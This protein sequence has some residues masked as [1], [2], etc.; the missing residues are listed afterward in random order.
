MKQKDFATIQGFETD[1]FTHKLIS[2][3]TL[4]RAQDADGIKMAFQVM[5][6]IS[7]MD[8]TVL[9]LKIQPAQADA[10]TAQ[11]LEATMVDPQGKE[12][13]LVSK[14]KSRDT[15]VKVDGHW[16]IKSSEDFDGSGTIDGQATR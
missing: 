11:T 5:K 3:K 6:V 12:H 1:D 2:G 15:W 10:V 8:V 13:A 9:D 4:T 16:K 7:K 14:S